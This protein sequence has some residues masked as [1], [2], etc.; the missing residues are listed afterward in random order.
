M[1]HSQRHLYLIPSSRLNYNQYSARSTVTKDK[2]GNPAGSTTDAH[3]SLFRGDSA[4]LSHG[5]LAISTSTLSVSPPLSLSL[6]LSLYI[7]MH[8]CTR[9]Q[10][11][12]ETTTASLQYG[13]FPVSAGAYTCLSRFI[14]TKLILGSGDMQVWVLGFWGLGLQKNIVRKEL[15]YGKPTLSL[16]DHQKPQR[17]SALG[18]VVA[19]FKTATLHREQAS[20]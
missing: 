2:S 12:K 13:N 11:F 4:G 5:R 3:P 9:I 7:Y 14:C 17:P 6:S 20:A 19:A 18:F 16:K 15:V 8:R 10:G 1:L